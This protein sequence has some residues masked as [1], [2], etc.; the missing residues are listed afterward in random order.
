MSTKVNARV[1]GTVVPTVVN[2]QG[3]EDKRMG[4]VVGKG[5][6]PHTLTH[7]PGFLGIK[8]RSCVRKA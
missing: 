4:K 2:E 7:L 8:H 6:W 5:R 1:G 3:G